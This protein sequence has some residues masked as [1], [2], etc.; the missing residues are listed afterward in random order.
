MLE[1][2]KSYKVKEWFANKIAQEMGRNIESCDVFAVIKETEKAVYALLNLG[3]DRRKTT[4]VPKS[5]LIQHEVGADENGLM[6]YETVFEEDYEKCV[7]L[8]KEHWRDF[9]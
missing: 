7:E 8:F 4:W 3:C 9:K 2:G 6:R 5:C 1:K